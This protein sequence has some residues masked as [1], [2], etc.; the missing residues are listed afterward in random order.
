MT[1]LLTIANGQSVVT[2]TIYEARFK[3][4]E[5]LRRMG[6]KIR[7]LDRTAI[8]DGVD[9]LIGAPVSATDLRAG[10]SMVV[11]GLLAEGA[12]EISGLRYILRGYEDIDLKLRALGARMS[13]SSAR[14][15]TRPREGLPC[16]FTRCTGW[17]TTKCTSTVSARRRR[18]TRARCL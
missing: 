11:A 7:I 1:S 10:A 9:R 15:G 12:T 6:A 2:E 8:W 13:G 14:P 17:A 5:E 18:R 3:Y 4:V 16:A